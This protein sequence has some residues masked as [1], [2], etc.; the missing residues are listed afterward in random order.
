MIPVPGPQDHP[1]RP[2]P[3]LSPAVPVRRTGAGGQRPG[4]VPL[5][6]L[7]GFDTCAVA[8]VAAALL[9]SGPRLALIWADPFTAGLGFVQTRV[10][11]S[12]GRCT[13][14]A[15]DLRD[16]DLSGTL[17]AAVTRTV[18]RLRRTCRYEAILVHVHP[19]I[20]ADAAID[21]LAA[22][23]AGAAVVDTVALCLHPG[24]LDDLGGDATAMSRGIAITGN[25]G[26]Y[27]A[28]ILA[29]GLTAATVIIAPADPGPAAGP[30]ERALLSILAPDAIRLHPATPLDVTAAQLV[31]T[32][33]FEPEVLDPLAARGLLDAS[34]ALPAECGSLRLVRWV[35]G[36][37]V[38]PQRLH[39]AIGGLADGVIRSVGYLRFATRPRQVVYWDSAGSSLVLGLPETVLTQP[40]TGGLAGSTRQAGRPAGHQPAGLSSPAGNH[41]AF[42]GDDLS[43]EHIHGLLDSCLL[44]DAELSAGPAAWRQLTDPFPRW[45]DDEGS[46]AAGNSTE[47]P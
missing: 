26:R 6:V 13:D 29:A 42:V 37:P 46:T 43:S 8:D 12:D 31:R 28:R 3:S 25:D 47:A 36:R 39:D 5:T 45:E 10:T 15:V 9:L 34:R 30:A 7:C 21:D 38:H 19:G 22:D 16:G 14:Q 33:R 23:L 18:R 32:G 24:W 44:T 40:G 4:V 11:D 2:R 27:A 17:R 20:E 1:P 41:L 35:T